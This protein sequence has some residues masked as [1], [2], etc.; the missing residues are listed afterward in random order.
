M[1]NGHGQDHPPQ[2]QG[3]QPKYGGAGAQAPMNYGTTSPAGG[4]TSAPPQQ[5]QQQEQ[6]ATGLAGP[7]DGGAPPPSYAQVVAGDHKVQT[8]D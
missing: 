5:H 7:S 6:G 1:Q 8:Q 3:I 4:S 2:Q